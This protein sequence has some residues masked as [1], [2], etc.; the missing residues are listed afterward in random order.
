M[1]S[2]NE[3]CFS[4]GQLSKSKTLCL[5]SVAAYYYTYYLSPVC[6][7]RILFK[8]VYKGKDKFK[9]IIKEMWA[10]VVHRGIGIV[11]ILSFIYIFPRSGL[12]PI[13]DIPLSSITYLLIYSQYFKLILGCSFSSLY[14]FSTSLMHHFFSDNRILNYL[15]IIIFCI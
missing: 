1:V 11:L 2:N 7:W 3:T 6:P 9:A 14:Y 15:D 13:P 4:R 10:T 12:C 5:L 8:C